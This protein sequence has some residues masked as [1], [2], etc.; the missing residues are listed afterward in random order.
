MYCRNRLLVKKVD[1][2]VGFLAFTGLL[3]C[4]KSLRPAHRT[5]GLSI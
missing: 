1:L 2:E 3:G 4:V 5:H